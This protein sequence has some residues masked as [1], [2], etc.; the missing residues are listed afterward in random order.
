MKTLKLIEVDKIEAGDLLVF[1]HVRLVVD[2]VERTAFLT[3]CNF[4]IEGD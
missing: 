1:N 3:I 4:T 2:Y